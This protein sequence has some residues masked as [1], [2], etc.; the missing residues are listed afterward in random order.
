MDAMR[1]LSK[2]SMLTCA[3]ILDIMIAISSE[4]GKMAMIILCI[5]LKHIAARYSV[6]EYRKSSQTPKIEKLPMQFANQ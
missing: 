3:L 4:Q 1:N 2:I 5:V 6:M